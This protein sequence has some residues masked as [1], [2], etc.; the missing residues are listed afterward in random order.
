MSLEHAYNSVP[1]KPISN[2]SC[3]G[4]IPII[5]RDANIIRFENNVFQQIINALPPPNPIEQNNDVKTPIVH[6]V[7][8]EDAIRELIEME[9]AG[10]L[11]C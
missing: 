1:N 5:Q 3:G 4:R 2:L 10:K 9:K 8:V 11:N 6:N 7:S